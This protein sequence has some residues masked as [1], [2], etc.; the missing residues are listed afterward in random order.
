MVLNCPWCESIQS[1]PS[2]YGTYREF[3]DFYTCKN[4][5]KAFSIK[6]TKIER[7]EVKDEARTQIQESKSG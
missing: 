7:E 4:C 3:V 2:P 6:V 5:H 1:C